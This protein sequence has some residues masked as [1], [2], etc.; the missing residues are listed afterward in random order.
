MIN[1]HFII[2]LLFEFLEYFLI[3]GESDQPVHYHCSFNSCIPGLL[4]KIYDGL[5]CI[6]YVFRILKISKPLKL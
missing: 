1:V 2:Y 6:S 5:T 4:I 3:L